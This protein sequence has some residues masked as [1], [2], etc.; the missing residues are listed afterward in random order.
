MKPT[1]QAGKL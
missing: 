1:W